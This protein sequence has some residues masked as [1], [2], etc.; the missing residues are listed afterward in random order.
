MNAFRIGAIT[1]H[2]I[3]EW[4][5]TFAPPEYLFR[6][7]EPSGWDPHE[8]EFVPDFFRRE[9]RKLYAFLQSWVL[10]TGSQRILFDTGAGNDKVRPGIPLFGN[11]QTNFLERLALV[12]F[13]PEDIDIVVCSHIHVDH[14]GWNT[15]LVDG[16][17]QVTFPNAR[18]VLPMADRD[19]WDPSVS[20]SGPGEIGTLV[21]AG[22]FEDSVLPLVQARRAEWAEDGLEIL[23]GLSLHA[24]P[25]HTPGSMI[26]RVSSG[27][28]RAMFVGDIVHHPAQVY[29][30]HWNS[31]YCEDQDQ[32]RLSRRLVL[33]EAA[34]TGALL[35]P[36]H[37]GGA[38]AIR[39]AHEGAA[40]KPIYL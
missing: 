11:L 26:L 3:E 36:A 19:Y 18:Y 22:M 8:A 5:G 23:P 37:F 12:G 10:D 15:R 29:N 20:T 7:F 34:D 9:D 27:E 38:H 4:Q 25:G 32:A 17:W 28:S 31:L 21:N 24:R 35:V 1:V 13:Q 16:K 30:P 14:V 39:V 2:R 33:N 40:F 6:G